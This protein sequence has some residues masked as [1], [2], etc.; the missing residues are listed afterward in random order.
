MTKKHFEAA[1]KIV[2]E[3]RIK[4]WTFAVHAERAYIELFQQFN[5]KFDV[6][7]FKEACQPSVE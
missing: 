5:P 1:A 7:R 2:R 4:G 3:A 6:E